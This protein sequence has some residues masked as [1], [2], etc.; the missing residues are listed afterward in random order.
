MT[1]T[2]QS[3]L[4]KLNDG[5]MRV[6]ELAEELHIPP[7]VLRKR[8]NQMESNGW[9]KKDGSYYTISIEYAPKLNWSFK[10]L[11]KVWK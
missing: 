4:D 9:V 7:N 1:E 8:L 11:L 5:D 10:E 3:I 6:S 2:Q